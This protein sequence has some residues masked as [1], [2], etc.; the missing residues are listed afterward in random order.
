M[1]DDNV[2]EFVKKNIVFRRSSDDSEWIIDK[3]TGKTQHG[4]SGGIVKSPTDDAKN[5]DKVNEAFDN[6]FI[7]KRNVVYERTLF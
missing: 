5:L 2:E 3:S 6:H 1:F 7:G 4:T